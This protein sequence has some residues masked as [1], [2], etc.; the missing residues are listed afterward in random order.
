MFIKPTPFVRCQSFFF[1]AKMYMVAVV[2]LYISLERKPRFVI[3]A[4]FYGVSTSMASDKSPT[5]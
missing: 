5:V 4:K 2:C 3:F 1:S